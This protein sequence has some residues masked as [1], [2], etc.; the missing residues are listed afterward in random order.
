[1]SSGSEAISSPLTRLTVLQLKEELSKHGLD[2]SGRKAE[3]IERLEEHD[4]QLPTD[5]VKGQSTLC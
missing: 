5:E 1:M 3:L 2:Q 4:T